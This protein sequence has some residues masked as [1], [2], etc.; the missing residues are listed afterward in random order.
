MAWSIAGEII[1]QVAQL[2]R[3][4]PDMTGG[5]SGESNAK[6][7]GVQVG[8]RCASGPT[9]WGSG[10]WSG[11]DSGAPCLAVRPSSAGHDRRSSPQ[12]SAINS[13]LRIRSA[14]P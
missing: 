13:M 8:L 11:N 10:Q 5:E 7:R 6:S 2:V 1:E 9:A 4:R 14:S 12:A 3:P